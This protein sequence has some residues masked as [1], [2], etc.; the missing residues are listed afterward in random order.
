VPGE[1]VEGEFSW[2]RGSVFDRLTAYIYS[3]LL[4]SKVMEITD[5][6]T[7]CVEKRYLL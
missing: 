2:D 5:V 4:A 6:T 1:Q 3:T 7:K